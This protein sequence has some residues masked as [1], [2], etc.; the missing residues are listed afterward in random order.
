MGR[1]DAKIWRGECQSKHVSIIVGF[2]RVAL[3]HFFCCLGAAKIVTMDIFRAVRDRF[4]HQ[5]D[6]EESAEP[7]S[8]N[9]G[10]SA[11]MQAM[12]EA[13]RVHENEVE[14]Q[15]VTN[16]NSSNNNNNNNN[17]C[18]NDATSKTLTTMSP[19][20]E[21]THGETEISTINDGGSTENIN[22]NAQA[23]GP[24]FSTPVVPRKIS[25]RAAWQLPLHKKKPIKCQWKK[26]QA[27]VTPTMASTGQLDAAGKAYEE[28]FAARV[29]VPVTPAVASARKPNENDS[30]SDR[31]S[32]NSDDDD[33][34]NPSLRD[35]VVTETPL[36]SPKR[37]GRSAEAQAKAEKKMK[38]RQPPVR[39]G[40]RVK[41]RRSH[42]Y[43]LLPPN[44]QEYLPR[45]HPNFYNYYG[46]VVCKTVGSKAS[47]DVHF[48]VFRDNEVATGLRQNVFT[49]LPKNADK[50]ECDPKYEAARLRENSAV[51]ELVKDETEHLTE[52]EFCEQSVEELQAAKIFV[53][54]FQNKKIDPIEW[55]IHAP[56]DEIS[57]CP[58]IEAL[59]K[60][61]HDGPTINKT[62]YDDM[63]ELSHGQFFLKHMWPSMEGFGCKL[64]K[65]YQ[66][67]QVEMM[68]VT[69]LLFQA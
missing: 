50:P 8:D 67:P 13:V 28:E 16:M 5:S 65:Y 57:D 1:T 56:N 45:N 46:S 33:P 24:T 64:D 23:V 32:S 11:G 35:R 41:A 59:K 48:D 44:L 3:Q 34:N 36:L 61:E 21:M 47:Y 18:H 20:P 43:H 29:G 58:I 6:N 15:N 53:H 19:L 69:S 66:D 14:D 68:Y 2:Y 10:A 42:I 54:N 39:K 40:S 4:S 9:G 55:K 17:I 52:Q 63:Q 51:N 27:T 37:K 31:S 26:P 30:D 62:V 49:T 12:F 7:T 25:R 60:D 22:G 38:A